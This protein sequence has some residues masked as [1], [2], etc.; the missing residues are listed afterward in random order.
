MA[1]A[2]EGS[3]APAR[4]AWRFRCGRRRTR[5]GASWSGKRSRSASPPRPTPGWR[6]TSGSFRG[7]MPTSSPSR[8]SPRFAAPS[9]TRLRGRIPAGARVPPPPH[10]GDRPAYRSYVGEIL[11]VKVEESASMRRGSPN[12]ESEADP[13]RPRRS[14]LITVSAGSSARVQDRAGAPVTRIAHTPRT[15][16]RGVKRLCRGVPGACHGG[17]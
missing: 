4:P 3:A 8:S 5:T 11:D 9:W 16:G 13:V 17:S 2:W 15:A 1:A 7:G 6:T 12:R 14:T 10:A